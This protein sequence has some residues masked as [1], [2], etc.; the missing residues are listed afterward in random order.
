M[1]KRGVFICIEGIDASGKTTHARQL[2]ENLLHRGLDSVYTTEPTSGEIGNLIK[3]HI[4]Q[5]PQRV[6][7][8]IEALL[9]AADR[10]E[11][12]ENMIKPA[13]QEG[14][15]IISDR[16]VYSSLAYQGADGLDLKWIEE[17]NKFAVQP[18]LAIYIDIPAE[19]VFERLKREKSIMENLQTQDRVREVYLKLV[20]EGKLT[21]INGNR[22]W[23]EVE[24]DI[25]ALVLSFLEKH[26][27]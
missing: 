26:L 3:T 23:D 15:I 11:H 7:S 21:L 12:I 5:S 6:P 25:L 1:G 18:D 24:K 27:V 14:K 4:L 17:I 13:L 9:F 16:Y 10:I 8:T 20:K 19:V 22:Q 2:V